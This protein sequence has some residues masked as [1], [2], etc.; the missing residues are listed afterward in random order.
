MVCI[1]AILILILHFASVVMLSGQGP[2][3]LYILY[4]LGIL[5]NKQGS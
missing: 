2:E 3:P 4:E 1:E 5:A